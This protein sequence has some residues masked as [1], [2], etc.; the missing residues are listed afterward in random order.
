MPVPNTKGN[1]PRIAIQYPE[2]TVDGGR[3]PAKRVRGRHRRACPPTSSAT[4]TRSCARSSA[5]AGPASRRWR[6]VARCGRSTRTSTAC[7]GRASS[8][9]TR[10]A[11]GSASIEAWTDVFATWR[12]ELQRKVAAGQEDLAGELSEGVVLLEQAADARQGRRRRRADRGTRSP[13]LEDETPESPSTTPRSAPSCSPPIERAA[14]RT[15]ALPARHAA[16]RS[17]ST[18]C[19]RRFGSW[20]ELFPRS[21]GRPQGRREADPRARRARLRRPLPAADPPD[22][23]DEPQGPQQHARP[24]APTTPAR[25]GRS[26]ARSG[27]HDAVH[28]E[29]GT[30]DDL[31]ALTATAARARHGHRARLRAPARRPT[32]RG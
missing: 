4:A 20:Y 8:R 18:A 21:L 11:A 32:T 1:P 28:P 15:G 16:D 14:E 19:A 27:G 3:Y 9:S 24:P 2:P 5:T 13:T 12:D 17:R 30:I 7:A 10:W 25:R 29:L 31:R 23:R 6:R 26:A 22:R